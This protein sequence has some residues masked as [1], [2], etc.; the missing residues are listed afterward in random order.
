LRVVY[1][2]WGRPINRIA[3]EVVSLKSLTR[4]D[5]SENL[6]EA[7]PSFIE[8]LPKLKTLVLG[9]NPIRAL[10]FNPRKLPSLEFLS[11]GGRWKKQMDGISNRRFKVVYSE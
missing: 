10:E 1:H 3:D 8:T 2:S 4:L 9:E 5:L 7:V 11:I 6:I